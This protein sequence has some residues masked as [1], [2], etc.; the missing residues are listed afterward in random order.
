MKLIAIISTVALLGGCA[1]T[2]LDTGKSLALA[3]QGLDA[4]SVSADA[5]VHAGKLKGAQAALAA[6]D[7]RKASAA[8]TAATAAYGVAGSTTNPGQQIAIATAATAELVA[9]ISGVQ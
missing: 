8:L 9:I 3:W 7:L 1:T 2:S 5:A 4:A 6:A